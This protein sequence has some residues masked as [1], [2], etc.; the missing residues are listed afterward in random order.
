MKI[1]VF[2]DA[3]VFDSAFQ[4]TTTYLNGLYMALVKD[5]DFEI[6]LAAANI[7]K[8]KKQF[9]DERF[10]FI[11][12]PSSSKFKRLAFDI[13]KLIKENEYDYAH[14]QY[15]T[16]FKKSCFFINTIHDLLFLDFPQYFPLSYRITKFL[17][18]RFSAFRS[19]IVCT[20]SNYSK[21]ALIKHF[22][23]KSDKILLTP[24]AVDFK[25]E[26]NI[27]VKKK[28]DLGKYILFVSRFEPRKNHYLLLKTFVDLELFKQGYTLV[29]IGRSK[30]VETVEYNKLLN[31]LPDNIKTHILQLENIATSE[32]QSFYTSADLFVYPSLAEGFG[33]PPLEAGGLKC[34]VLCSNQTAMNDFDFFGKYLF[35]PTIPGDLKNKMKDVLNDTNYPFDQ[36]KEAINKKYNWSNIAF[37][38]GQKLK[39]HYSLVLAKK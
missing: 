19:D 37:N 3:H 16:P 18:F 36:I 38:F 2:V 22:H 30:D 27:D 26:D 32:L 12:L 33:I 23:L 7:N 10:K 24:N 4:G 6:T 29:L 13:P 39:E 11:E 14:F 5:P 31:S 34:K 35:N 28:Y 1:K 20:V 21:F 17:T 15:I 25:K 8:L 9:H